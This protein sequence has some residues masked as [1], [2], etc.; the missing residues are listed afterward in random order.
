[1][2]PESFL[3]RILDVVFVERIYPCHKIPNSFDFAVCY[4]AVH[5]AT[6]DTHIRIHIHI[7]QSSHPPIH[8][9]GSLLLRK[10]RSAPTADRR[11]EH[12][13]EENNH[14]GVHLGIHVHG[15]HEDHG[16]QVCDGCGVRIVDFI[17][18]LDS[19][20]ECEQPHFMYLSLLLSTNST[21]SLSHGSLP[22]VKV[23]LQCTCSPSSSFSRKLLGE[24]CAS[25]D[26]L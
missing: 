3:A 11:P 7:H 24:N 19:V 15:S 5:N 21:S 8:P 4:F 16:E 26:A 2:Q 17:G 13:P 10:P 20:L 18:G 1:V 14:A 23:V 12:T 22:N 9:S 25:L 6:D